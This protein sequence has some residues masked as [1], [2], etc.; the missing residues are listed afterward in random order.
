MQDRTAPRTELRDGLLWVLH[1]DGSRR[2]ATLGQAC[3]EIARL[4]RGWLRVIQGE[5][6]CPAT[7][8][9]CLAKRCGC[10]EEME[11]LAND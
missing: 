9:G 8:G 3:A 2:S 6:S 11:M 4:R 7:G 1:P 10:V 5:N